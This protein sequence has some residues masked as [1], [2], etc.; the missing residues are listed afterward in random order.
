MTAVVAVV[1]RPVVVPTASATTIHNDTTG[2]AELRP[3]AFMQAV[4]LATSGMKSP[5]SR[6]ASGVQA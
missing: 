1:M 2:L 4:T 5:H 6:I 3:L